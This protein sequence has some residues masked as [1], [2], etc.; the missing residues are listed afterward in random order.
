MRDGPRL[1]PTTGED[2]DDETRELLDSLGH[3]NLFETLAHHSK[4]LKRW[5]VFANHVLAKSTLPARERELAILRTGWR[6]GSEYEFG[7]HTVI[8]ATVGITAEEVARLTEDSLDCWSEADAELMTATD[9]LVD[10]HMLSEAS[11]VALNGRWDTQQVL[12]LIFTVGQYVLVSSVLR[13]LGVELD[14]GA[15]GWPA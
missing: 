10:D 13:S 11:W 4:L 7:Q 1:A 6:C 8:G 3:L 9:E 12:D 15:P 2:W 5:L 14:D